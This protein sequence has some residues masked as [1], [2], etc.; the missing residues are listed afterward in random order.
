MASGC[1]HSAAC[2]NSFSA[3]PKKITPISTDRGNHQAWLP[4][5]GLPQTITV[6][7]PNNVHACK[8]KNL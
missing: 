2:R 1:P 5:S 6:I 3:H 4:D 7:L 8:K